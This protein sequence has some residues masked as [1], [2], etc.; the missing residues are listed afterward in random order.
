[1]RIHWLASYPKSG[2]TWVRFLLYY[3]I[4][5]ELSETRVLNERIPECARAD[6]AALTAQATRETP[7]LVKTHWALSPTMPHAEH[8]AGAIYII[9]H[10]KDVLLSLINFYRLRD[11]ESKWTDEQIVR[12]FINSGGDPSAAKMG[13]GTW[14]ENVTTWLIQR[15][16]P[17]LL[18]RYED[19]KKDSS[20][21]L[22][23]MVEFIGMAVDDARVLWAA[24]Q[25]SFEKMKALEIREKSADVR[26]SAFDGGRAELDRGLMFMNRG[27]VGQALAAV[28][29]TLDQE[30][31]R[32]FRVPT[33]LLDYARV[34]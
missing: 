31:D 27:G 1:M 23:R 3:Y 30:F 20:Q 19:L 18:V 17:L 13:F 2:N 5:G 16:F 26:G 32:R 34:S 22:R 4:Y 9:R 28:A 15:R 8:T 14:V 6:L 29:P 10:P 24:D 11:P 33:W 12:L 7:L 25:C 21:E